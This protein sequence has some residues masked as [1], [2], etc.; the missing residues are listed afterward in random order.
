M[1]QKT[2]FSIYWSAESVV[3]VLVVVVV[4]VWY[5]YIVQI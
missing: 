3:V 2:I 5:I 4:V 1:A